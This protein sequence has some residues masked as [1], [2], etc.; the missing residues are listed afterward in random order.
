V[1]IE[2]DS[3]PLNKALSTVP[4]PDFWVRSH[5]HRIRT[6]P[7]LDLA[8]GSGR[9]GRLFLEQG[10]T[11]HFL[12]RDLSGVEDLRGSSSARLHCHDL[13]NGTAWPF[14]AEYFQ[15]IVVVNYLHRPLL[16]E[17][18]HWLKPGG[19]LLYKTFACGNEQYGRPSNPDYLLH[20]NELMDVFGDAMDVVDCRQQ[21]ETSPQRVTQHL[22]AVKP[23][24]GN[25]NA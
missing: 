6:G 3:Q 21:M 20:K 16:T 13:E 10:L 15:G 12:D 9:H 19:V 22:C 25:Y 2:T 18:A 17:L 1:N 4:P 23:A 5:M 11:V 8:C 24:P 7:V 14:S